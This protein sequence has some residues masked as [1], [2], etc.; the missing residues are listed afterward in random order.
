MRSSYTASPA[1]RGDGCLLWNNCAS[2]TCHDEPDC[3]LH[4]AAQL[5]AA[6]RSVR[7]TCAGGGLTKF[8]VAV[9]YLEQADYPG[10]EDAM[11]WARLRA[12]F[13]SAG[14]VAAYSQACR[15]L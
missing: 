1:D 8:E 9:E 4:R 11:L 15:T 5:G 12:P 10:G 2:G 13:P 14:R 7:K 3:H 6:D